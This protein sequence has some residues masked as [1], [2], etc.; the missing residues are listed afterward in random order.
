MCNRKSNSQEERYDED[1]KFY[2]EQSAVLQEDIDFLSPEPVAEAG[3]APEAVYVWY[4]W[5]LKLIGVIPKQDKNVFY[6][7]VLMLML[8]LNGGMVIPFVFIMAFLYLRSQLLSQ[9]ATVETYMKN[10]GFF[11]QQVDMIADHGGCAMLNENFTNPETGTLMTPVQAANMFAGYLSHEVPMVTSFQGA[12]SVTSII[13]MVLCLLLYFLAIWSIFKN[14]RRVA[15]V[16]EDTGSTRSEFQKL[17]VD[18]EEFNTRFKPNLTPSASAKMLGHQFYGAMFSLAMLGFFLTLIVTLLGWSVTL[19]AIWHQMLPQIAWA[20]GAILLQTLVLNWMLD[21]YCTRQE[22]SEFNAS[23]I[24]TRIK[25]PVA[26]SLLYPFAIFFHFFVGFLEGFKRIFFFV[27]EALRRVM[28]G[29]TSLHA[30]A[31]VAE[32]DGLFMGFMATLE[33]T[34]AVPSIKSKVGEHFE[35][36][37]MSERAAKKRYELAAKAS[38][39][40]L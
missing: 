29:D 26:F 35:G 17:G 39:K 18:R 19:E 4:R 12:F 20:L 22:I 15:L 31:R 32:S 6:F 3:E 23:A 13:A 40:I 30:A 11:V 14:F 38:K 36:V 25:R 28:N 34:S 27:Y 5:L 16:V 2:E 10:A 9:L 24:I 8:L 7:P 33:L 21:A 1:A 37:Q